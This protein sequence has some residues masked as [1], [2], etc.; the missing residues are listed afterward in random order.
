MEEE[1]KYTT[2]QN[3]NIIIIYTL[4][5]FLSIFIFQSAWNWYLAPIANVDLLPFKNAFFVG[6]V[7]RVIFKNTPN[8]NPKETLQYAERIKK[9]KYEL[10]GSFFTILALYIGK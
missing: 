7:F 6:V 3:L 5:V 2:E 10:A 1:I 8:F 9:I 4:K